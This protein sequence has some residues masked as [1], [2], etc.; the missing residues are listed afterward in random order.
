MAP[1]PTGEA[2]ATPAFDLPAPIKH[3]IHT[4]GPVWHGGSSGEDEQLASCYRRCLEVADEL[5]A[6]SVAFPAISTGVYGYPAELAAEV[7]APTLRSTQRRWSWCDWWRSAR[8]P[9]R[10]SDT[11]W[12]NID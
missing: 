11:R 7:V 5:R 12:Q 2:K 3:V 9:V 6:R 10:C 4:V 1:C 8:R